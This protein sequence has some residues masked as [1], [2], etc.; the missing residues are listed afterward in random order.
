MGNTLT[1]LIPVMYEGLNR[2]SRELVGF[3]RAVSLDSV[4]DSAALNQ[5]VRSPVAPEATTEAVTPGAA[6]ANSGTQTIGYADITIT[7][8]EVSP[9]M[10][11]GEEQLSVGKNLNE[12][13]VQQFEQ[14]VR[15][16]VKKV[17]ADVY[18]VGYKG[19]SRAYG[20]VGTT[21]FGTAGNLSDFAEI[22]RILED[23]GAPESDLHLVLGTAARANIRGKQSGLFEV[24]R[25]G[26]DE[27][28]RRG[29]IGDV[30][31]LDVHGSSSIKDVTSGTGGGYLVDLAAGYAVGDTTIHVD[32]GTGTILA[33][34]V[35]TFAGD[36][37]KYVV[38]VGFAGDGDGDITLAEPGLQAALADNAAL[39]ILG[40]SPR[41]LAF[42]RSALHLAARLPAMPMVNGKP[43]DAA[44][45]VEVITDPLSGLSFQV[46]IYEQYRRIKY[47]IGIAWGAA[48]IKPQHIA[49]LLG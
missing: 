43:A 29:I 33:G 12:T 38:S 11:S 4:A 16:L 2:V 28:L 26:S 44:T 31:G 47:E 34:D 1:G 17:E 30:M 21:P 41:N 24:N 27:L 25:S 9:I 37:N 45:D 22:L 42:A 35:I 13:M 5:T 19:A 20:T 40:A 10:W 36:S 15:A 3:T 49:A 48:A 46:A 14:S 18:S 7:D 39:T 6:P 32:T 8:S 23:N